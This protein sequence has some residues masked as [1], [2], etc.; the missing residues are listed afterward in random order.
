MPGTEHFTY[1]NSFKSQTMLR[2]GYH[3]NLFSTD[4]KT[5]TL[6]LNNLP[7]FTTPQVQESRMDPGKCI[8]ESLLCITHF[9]HDYCIVLHTLMHTCSLILS[10]VFRWAN[11][12]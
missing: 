7:E 6:G 9:G 8:S 1:L 5:K 2:G 3:Y 10:P 11:Y 4:E 12:S